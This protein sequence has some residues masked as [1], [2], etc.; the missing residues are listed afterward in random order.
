MS[1]NSNLIRD[2]LIDSKIIDLF[3]CANLSF[4]GG[5]TAIFERNTVRGIVIY[6]YSDLGGWIE[7]LQ[8]GNTIIKSMPNFV[9]DDEIKTV[10][11]LIKEYR[12]T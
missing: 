6:R 2:Y 7:F 3:V 10:N 9:D 5:L 12:I 4:E 8:V 11:L 1:D